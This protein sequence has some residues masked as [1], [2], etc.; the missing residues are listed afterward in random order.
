MGFGPDVAGRTDVVLV[1]TPQCLQ[2][3]A[4]PRSRTFER[5]EVLSAQDHEITVAAFL[6][7][8]SVPR[9]LS[10]DRLNEFVRS[11]LEKT[12]IASEM[13]SSGQSGNLGPGFC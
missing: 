5:I 8:D 12:G 3:L 7:R 1:L 10:M 6:T 9:L 2:A 13:D 11:R 4:T